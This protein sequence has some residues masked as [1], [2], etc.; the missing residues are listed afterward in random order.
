MQGYWT[1]RPPEFPAITKPS[2]EPLPTGAS[3]PASGNAPRR[4]RRAWCHHLQVNN[5]QTISIASPEVAAVVDR[6]RL[7]TNHSTSTSALSKYGL[8]STACRLRPGAQL[9]DYAVD[10]CMS[11][12]HKDCAW[13]TDHER[14]P[15]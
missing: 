8:K 3:A 12:W 2:H 6:I 14:N 10:V 5:S 4:L 15:K 13:K 11:N 7:N 9:G 1:G